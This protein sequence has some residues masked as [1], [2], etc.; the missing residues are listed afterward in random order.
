MTLKLSVATPVVTMDP[1]T[2]APWEEDASIEE[3]ARIA[4][5][6]TVNERGRQSHVENGNKFYD[7]SKYKEASIMYRR[8]IA[9]NADPRYGEAYYRL[10]LTAL[11]LSDP[12]GGYKMLLNATDLQKD[13]TD[14]LTKLTDLEILFGSQGGR[15]GEKLVED[16]LEHAKKLATMKDGAYDSARMQGQIALI[17][18]QTPEAITFF[19][20][21]N[22]LKPDQ[23]NLI[24][25]LFAALTQDN[26]FPRAEGIA[27]NLISKQ[28]DYGPIY[29]LLYVQYMLRKQPVEAA[30]VLK[31]KVDNNPKSVQFVL[32]LAAHYAGQAS[33]R[34]WNRP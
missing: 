32:Q 19:E 25:A 30:Q 20:K 2:H 12:G 31:Q 3:L 6:N 27:K 9:S 26:Q 10:G 23:A 33:R 22:Q 16:A 5:S 29:D 24:L 15:Q 17:K 4:E 8:A 21:A 14:A 11:K 28:K 13:N 18:K 1:K 34:S 7:R